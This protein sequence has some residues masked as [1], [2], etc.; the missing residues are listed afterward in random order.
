[1]RF[2]TSLVIIMGIMIIVGMTLLGVKISDKLSSPKKLPTEVTETMISE[3]NIDGEI[4]DIAVMGDEL[5]L[6]IH[7]KTG[8]EVIFL[9]PDTGIVSKQIKVKTPQP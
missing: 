4:I 3:I 2:L 7:S 6:H 1:M 5:V 8:K 9:N